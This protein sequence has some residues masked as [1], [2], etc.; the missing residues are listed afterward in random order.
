MLKILKTSI[1]KNSSEKYKGREDNIT[2]FH[3]FI[4][5]IILRKEI[6]EVYITIGEDENGNLF[7][8]LEENEKPSETLH[9]TSD[10]FSKGNNSII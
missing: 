5:K 3:Y 4:N 7:Y 2:F 9:H 8:D 10:V 1:Y 6:Y